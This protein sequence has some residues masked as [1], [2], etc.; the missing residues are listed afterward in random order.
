KGEHEP[1]VE[2]IRE[3]E[4]D[5]RGKQQV[6]IPTLLQYLEAEFNVAKFCCE[7]QRA[8]IQDV[9]ERQIRGFHAPRRKSKRPRKE[10]IEDR[11]ANQVQRHDDRGIAKVCEIGLNRPAQAGDTTKN[12][13]IKQSIE[14]DEK[15]ES[16]LTD[17][18]G[19]GRIL[20]G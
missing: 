8:E 14:L 1:I 16:V 2:S 17:D 15:R 7:S 5:E 11:S 18:G 20:L 3:K 4:I 9:I 19:Y 10:R 12:A 13:K 6:L